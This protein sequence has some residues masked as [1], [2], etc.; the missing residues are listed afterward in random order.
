MQSGCTYNVQNLLLL[1]EAEF[2][3]IGTPLLP[4]FIKAVTVMKKAKA[5][6][7]AGVSTNPI[8][9]DPCVTVSS[10]GCV[11]SFR[12]CQYRLYRLMLCTHAS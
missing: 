8:T 3:C 12:H 10:P 11:N 1:K 7:A 4:A 2:N 6:G 9:I 5:A